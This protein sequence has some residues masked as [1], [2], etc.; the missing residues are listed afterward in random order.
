LVGRKALV[1]PAQNGCV[2]VFDEQSDE[3]DVKQI[4][5]LA[6]KLSQKLACP[7]LAVLNHDDDI[8]WY[9]LYEGGAMSDEYD[10]SPGYF[11]P[12][13]EPSAPTGGNAQRLCSAFGATGVVAVERILRKS[14]YDD[15][16]YAFA[17]QRHADLSWSLGLPEFGVGVSYA[18]LERGEY[19]A[20][21]AAE[22]LMRA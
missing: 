19:P 22:G 9:R 5:E 20:G 2:L 6:S 17:F 16:G 13:A 11:D 8:L 4:S 21:L 12:A 7:V 3:Q 10:S 1:T 18:S 15:D 14:A